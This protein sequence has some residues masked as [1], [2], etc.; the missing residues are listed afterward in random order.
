M[1]ISAVLESRDS[2]ILLACENFLKSQIGDMSPLIAIAFIS[3]ALAIITQF[4]HN[5]VLLIIFVPMLCPLVQSYGINPV[6]MAIT[7]MFAVQ[8]A[9]LT[10]AASTQ[11]AMIFSNTKWIDKK[12]IFKLALCA[13]II[14]LVVAL[15]GVLPM[16]NIVYTG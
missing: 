1:P 5:A 16:A 2:G 7:L 14:M 3:I 11:A 8:S 13:M 10:P 12:Y 15:F 6:V 4:S 9:L